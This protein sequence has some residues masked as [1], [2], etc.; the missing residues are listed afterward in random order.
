[1]TRIEIAGCEAEV[2]W[3]DGWPGCREEP[4]EPAGW[5]VCSQW[6]LVD[7]EALRAEFEALEL[8][9]RLRAAFGLVEGRELPLVASEFFSHVFEEEIAR[10]L[11]LGGFDE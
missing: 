5:E 1:M 6:S 3:Q 9:D 4:G 8:W 11:V 7:A 10:A 2:R